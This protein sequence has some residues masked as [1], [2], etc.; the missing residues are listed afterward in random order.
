MHHNHNKQTWKIINND[1]INHKKNV[2]SD[3]PN[4]FVYEEKTLTDKVNIV[5]SFN[6]YFVS[7]GKKLADE[8]QDVS[9]GSIY[10]C[11]DHFVAQS[12]SLKCTDECEIQKI[13]NLLS[14]K[15]SCDC[16]GMSMVNIK[17][18]IK[19]IVKPLTVIYNQTFL[20]GIFPH[21]MKI[22]RAIHIF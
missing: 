12:M 10:N 19:A 6:D 2:P 8:I 11:L 3:F 18:I 21:G 17:M 22:A 5:N 1:I 9:N 14:S 20:T 4:S 7:V 13:V 15:M 16:N